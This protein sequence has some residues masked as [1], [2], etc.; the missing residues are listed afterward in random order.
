MENCKDILLFGEHTF[1]VSP[2]LSFLLVQ[3]TAGL[4]QKRAQNIEQTLVVFTA[5]SSALKMKG[6]PVLDHL[7]GMI[8]NYI[9]GVYIANGI[10][11]YLISV[12]CITLRPVLP[13]AR[14]H[15]LVKS[16][17]AD[18]NPSSI[19]SQ[20]SPNHNLCCALQSIGGFFHSSSSGNV[21]GYCQSSL[22]FHVAL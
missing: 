7:S 13:I 5:L 15:S 14:I 22:R 17:S 10:L 3:N 11:H 16:L 20:L 21:F 18:R 8:K 9:I 12:T 19:S 4:Y 2:M 6:I 1:G